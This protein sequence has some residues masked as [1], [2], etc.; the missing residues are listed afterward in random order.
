MSSLGEAADRE[1]RTVVQHVDRFAGIVRVLG[2]ELHQHID[3]AEA[4]L[5]GAAADARG[6]LARSVG[7]VHGEL[8][9][10]GRVIALLIRKKE[11]RVRP[12]I[13]SVERHLEFLR[14]RR[15]ERQRC[16]CG[17]DRQAADAK[18][19]HANPPMSCAAIGK[20]CAKKLGAKAADSS[21]PPLTACRSAPLFRG[22]RRR[23]PE[24]RRS[25]RSSRRRAPRND[26]GALLLNPP[27]RSASP[28][29]RIAGGRRRAGQ[30][31]A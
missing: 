17:R 7:R 26:G 6:D 4:E 12:V 24:F 23:N 29:A 5:V 15:R 3:V 28:A 1:R 27:C 11:R 22:R 30:G 9:A 31:S 18:T 8:E 19:W 25:C 2:V 16:N 21:M 20:R 14:Q 13:R 10:F